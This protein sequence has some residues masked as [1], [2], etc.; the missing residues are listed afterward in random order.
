MYSDL[1]FQEKESYELNSDGTY[2]IFGDGAKKF[3][4]RFLIK[5]FFKENGKEE[6]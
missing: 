3:R 1:G 4:E 2:S 6:D 5:D